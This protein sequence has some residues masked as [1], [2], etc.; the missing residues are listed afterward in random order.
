MTSSAEYDFP[1]ELELL[2]AAGP[3][4]LSTADLEDELLLL[5]A[6]SGSG[7]DALVADSGGSGETQAD[8]ASNVGCCTAA[9]PSPADRRIASPTDRDVLNGRGQGVQRSGGNVA[10]RKLVSANK[11]LYCRAKDKSKFPKAIVAAVRECGGRFLELDERTKS[12]REIGDKKAREKTQQALREGQ[13][14]IRQ[15]LHARGVNCGAEPGPGFDECFG[16]CLQVLRS[17]HSGD[18]VGAVPRAHCPAR[19]APEQAR[20]APIQAEIGSNDDQSPA[21]ATHV[22]TEKTT[23][24]PGKRLAGMSRSKVE[25]RRCNTRSTKHSY[26]SVARDLRRRRSATLVTRKLHI[27]HELRMY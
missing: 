5:F 6:E 13:K 2:D 24:A 16:Y 22:K 3:L 20:S 19:V 18:E 11:D 9:A 8:V 1:L 14:K 17:L 27:L 26:F 10:Y 21:A 12:Y 23:P 7:L 15:R 4:R 25:A